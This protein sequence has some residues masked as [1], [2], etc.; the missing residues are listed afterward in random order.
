MKRNCRPIVPLKRRT[1]VLI[2]KEYSSTFIVSPIP[3]FPTPQRAPCKQTTTV[4]SSGH[5]K[6]RYRSSSHLCRVSSG[7]SRFLPPVSSGLSHDLF[8]KYNANN[9]VLPRLFGNA[10]SS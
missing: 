9:A 6:T 7:F 2:C 3:V 1:Y 8:V 4:Q 10:A 5:D